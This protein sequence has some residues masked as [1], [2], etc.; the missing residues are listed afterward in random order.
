M[1]FLRKTYSFLRVISDIV[2]LY[3]TLVINWWTFSNSEIKNINHLFLIVSSALILI[4][5]ITSRETKIYDEFQ[6]RN[7]K[8]E[9]IGIFNQAVIQTI[10]L[11]AL[12]FLLNIHSHD[13][14]VVVAF[15]I[16][17]FVFIAIER[18]VFRKILEQLRKKGRNLRSILFV[19]G[20]DITLDLYD[21]I[22]KNAELGYFV[23]GF[24]NDSPIPSLNGKYLGKI[25]DLEKIL[26]SKKVDNVLI[27]MQQ[28]S[29]TKLNELIRIS[30]KYPTRVRLVKGYK[31]F[32]ANNEEL[33]IFDKFEIETVRKDY[34]YSAH[35]R[36]V[37]RMFDILF[38]T[39]VI[40]IIFPVVFPVVALIIKVT[41]KGPVFFK[42]ERWGR[43]NKKFKVIKFR[44]MKI[45]GSDKFVQASKDDPR[46]TGFG[47]F[48]R[49]TNLDEL[50]QFINVLKGEMSVVGPRP[51]PTP[52]NVLA[53][54]KIKNY[55]L[56][57]LVKPGITGWAQIHGFRG[58]TKNEELMQKRVE[59]DL[60]Y[61]ENWSLW[62]D[63][64]IIFKTILKTITGD[65][66]AY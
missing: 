26:E 61:I 4:W 52:L 11:V 40:L 19:G 50:P 14:I 21:K 2:V 31:S 17:A 13:K 16:S 41:S 36:I 60:W 6:I 37:K 62:L 5:L 7:I 34:L 55:M 64:K 10:S 22:N 57:H 8:F 1:D 43:G 66:N 23:T 25:S 44:T 51:H 59:Y 63:V 45:G 58:E 35:W 46:V 65:P 42:Q 47:K 56:R 49:R 27:N 33:H 48:L 12:L 3:F 28:F 54:D 24:L 15:G 18:I 9:M 29:D 39:F 30:E 38:S 32:A 20:N 53:K